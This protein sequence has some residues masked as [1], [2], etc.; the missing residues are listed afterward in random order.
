MPESK[1]HKNK[2]TEKYIQQV[3]IQKLVERRVDTLYLTPVTSTHHL[4]SVNRSQTPQNYEPP[5]DT[6]IKLSTSPSSSFFCTGAWLG[7]V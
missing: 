7:D 1:I 4:S 5:V 3:Y 6:Y 2:S